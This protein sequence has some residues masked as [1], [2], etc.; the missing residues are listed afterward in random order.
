MLRGVS[1]TLTEF[2]RE[3]GH[4]LERYRL[5]VLLDYPQHVDEQLHRQLLPLVKAGADA[6]VSFIIATTPGTEGKPD[7]WKPN[8]LDGLGNT[9][10]DNG[11]QLVWP[12]H[13]QFDVT[14]PETDAAALARNVDDLVLQAASASAPKVPF[15][16][17]QHLD[18]RWDE[19]SADRLRFAVGLAGP[20]VAEI[21][22]GDER[23]QRHNVLITGAV[24]Q[25]KSN[26][27]K[28]IIHSLGQR[29]S[30]DELELY[31]LDF[32]EGVT[33]FP[34]AP[35]PG[36]PDYLLHARVLGLESDRDFGLAVLRHVEAEFARRAKLFRP[37]GDS[38]SRYRA[39]VPEARMPR[40]V[41]VVD[42]FHMLFDPND[43]TAEAAA[44]LLEAIARRGRS[45]GVH[46][47]LA[48]QTVS[49][50]SALMTRE[51]GIFAQFPIR[52]ALKNAA[53]ESYATL[54]Q[55]ND[56]AA[57]LRVR[58]EAVL[59]LDYGHV[60]GNRQVVVAAADDQELAQL[61]HQWWLA[62][63]ETTP[64]PLVFDGSRLIRASDAMDTIRGLRAR[65]R[66]GSSA[67]ALVG[68]PIDVTG[69]PF[70]VQLGAEPG[71]NLAILGAGEPGGSDLELE[72]TNNAIGVL[73]TAALSLALQH[74]EGDAEFTS[75]EALDDATFERNEHHL[76]LTAM[77]RLG[78][79]VHRVGRGELPTYLQELAGELETREADAPPR[80]LFGYGLDRVTALD[81]PDMFAH[82]PS[83]D[84][85][86]ILR[87]GPAKRLH[88][89]GWWANAATFRSHIGYAGEGFIDALLML[90][91]D[92]GT[93]QDLLSPFI[94]WHI[95]DNRGLL[96][97]RTQLPEPTT[98]IPF[99]P[100]TAREASVLERAD[101]Q[102]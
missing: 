15:E 53:Q 30:P 40:I 94:T 49:G 67:V 96:A 8:E 32:K 24:G 82:K 14:I 62:S 39:A 65:A 20:S 85:Q 19:S 57:R 45:Y 10:K 72:P 27:L 90:R 79:P 55:G 56:A 6:G 88:L 59:N 2:R 78:Y 28:V 43:K 34:L 101:W 4:P 7:W 11:K 12:A 100:L 74:P 47:I 46:L 33:L 1:R 18:A 86:Q 97:D 31:L 38:I 13:A 54:G 80:Y 66:D 5:V 48:S 93:V 92:Q 69:Q 83:E 44:Q 21:T 87:T 51:G 99:A 25:G 75:I 17:V 91:L 60:D 95:R 35:T 22:L 61:R 29:Y 81:T 58:G 77:E 71:R 26:L 3:A 37:Y 16:R 84:L 42:E 73:Q 41:I 63:R 68:Y 76:W 9:L 50:I 89:L 64:P 52:L 102:A 23:E 36:S 98:I 70:G